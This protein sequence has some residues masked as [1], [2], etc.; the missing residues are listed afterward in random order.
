MCLGD[1]LRPDA[2]LP[3]PVVPRLVHAPDG[4]EA[5]LAP[6]WISWLTTPIFQPVSLRW[7]KYSAGSCSVYALRGSGN[8]YRRFGQRRAA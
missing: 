8:D 5:I 7:S 6:A 4:G 1:P 2:A 3:R